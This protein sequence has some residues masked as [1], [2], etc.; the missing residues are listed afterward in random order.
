MPVDRQEQADCSYGSP[1]EV[2]K[3]VD[4]V[5][6]YAAW[7]CPTKEAWQQ[8]N[9]NGKGILDFVG[10]TSDKVPYSAGHSYTFE[11]GGV[12]GPLTLGSSDALDGSTGDNSGAFKVT[13]TD[14]GGSGGG[15]DAGP[16][17]PLSRA[18][19]RTSRSSATT[20]APWTAATARVYGRR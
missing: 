2:G 12:S 5:W 1:Y 18:C 7:R 4:A 17:S 16:T 9:V 14:L 8:L 11:F 13:I 10:L 20:T 19:N 6:C 15:E 3:G